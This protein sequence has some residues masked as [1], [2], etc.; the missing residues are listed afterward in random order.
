MQQRQEGGVFVR[1]GHRSMAAAFSVP[2]GGQQ[3]VPAA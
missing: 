2:M 3:D 1:G